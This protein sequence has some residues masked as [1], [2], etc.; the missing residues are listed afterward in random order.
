MLRVGHCVKDW[1]LLFLVNLCYWCLDRRLLFAI[2]HPTLYVVD[3]C[4]GGWMQ[5]WEDNH[6]G[7]GLIGCIVSVG[8]IIPRGASYAQYYAMQ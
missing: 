1:C 7:V 3:V 8:V 2:W 6:S 4:I 5:Y